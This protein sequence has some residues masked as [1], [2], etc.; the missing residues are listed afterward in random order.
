MMQGLLFH[1]DLVLDEQVDDL[2]AAEKRD[3]GG[4]HHRPLIAA[5]FAT[6]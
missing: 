2:V 6:R 3:R 1:A 4:A 5:T